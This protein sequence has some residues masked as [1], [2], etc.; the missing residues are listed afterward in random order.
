MTLGLEAPGR[1]IVRAPIAP[2]YA[3]PYVASIQI[4]QRLAGH[5]VELL[6]AQDD[7]FLARGVDKYEGWIHHGFLSPE[8]DSSARRSSQVVRVSL[9]CVAKNP[10]GTRRSLPLGARLSPEEIV[11]SGQAVNQLE[12]ANRFPSDAVA[13]IRS[14]Q[15][16]FQGTSYLWGGVTPWGADCSGFVQSIYGLHGVALPRD[17]WQQSESGSEAGA[18]LD[19]KA[20]DLAFFSDREDR[21]VTHVAISLG[22]CRLVHLALGRGGYAT[23]NLNDSGDAYVAKLRERFLQAKKV[24]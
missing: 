5:P 9:G 23:E 17:A 6:E 19:L 24:L 1:A 11:T 13:I 21:R 22:H 16:F 2:M 15:D 12:L 3:E 4:S 18:L 20:A 10:G 7:W 14:A 8:P